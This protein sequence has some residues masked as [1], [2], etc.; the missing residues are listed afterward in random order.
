MNE[1]K[2]F[3]AKRCVL[4][5]S[6]A[7][8]SKLFHILKSDALTPTMSCREARR[9]AAAMSDGRGDP[10][11][12]SMMTAAPSNAD[13]RH[14]DLKMFVKPALMESRPQEFHPQ[15][16]AERCVS[17][18][19]HTAPIKQTRLASQVSSVRRAAGISGRPSARRFPPVSCFYGTACTS[20]SPRQ[21]AMC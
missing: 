9:C 14:A 4:H 13:V 20:S 6:A 15:P 2:I 19:T 18:S 7:M 11:P 17:L 3:N 16:L 21:P 1:G 10:H 5:K 12:L 8:N